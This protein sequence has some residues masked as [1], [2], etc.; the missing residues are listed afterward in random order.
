MGNTPPLGVGL[1]GVGW[2]AAQHLQAFQNNP[3]ARVVMLCSRNERRARERLAAAGVD[4][5]AARFT[6][7][8]QDLLDAP[9]VDIVSIATPNHLHADQP[10][11]SRPECE[12]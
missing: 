4:V 6:T 1:V 10:K 12:G 2:V 8:Y 5:P 9:E 11:S 7:R 3:Q